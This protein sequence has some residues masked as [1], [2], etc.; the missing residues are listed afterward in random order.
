[1]RPI[2]DHDLAL[3]WCP[4]MGAPE[5]IVSDLVLARL[6]ECERE[7]PLRLHST[8]H[9]ANDAI[10]AGGVKRLEY[11]EK[12]LVAIRI[13]QILQLVHALDVFAHLG[14]CGTLE[15]LRQCEWRRYEVMNVPAPIRHRDRLIGTSEPVLTG[16]ERIAFETL[17]IAPQGEPLTAFAYPK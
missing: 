10:F 14:R 17:L 11:D 4:K 9:V 6:L 16:Y 15:G 8:E 2:E 13:K 7:R 3:A 12:G 1:M 5:K